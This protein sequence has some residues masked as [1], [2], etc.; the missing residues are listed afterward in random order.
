MQ[1]DLISP[2]EQDIQSLIKKLHDERDEEIKIRGQ[3][4]LNNGMYNSVLW[5]GRQINTNGNGSN[6]EDEYDRE[7][8]GAIEKEKDDVNVDGNV[9]EKASNGVEMGNEME[10][11]ISSLISKQRRFSSN[12]CFRIPPQV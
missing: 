3:R 11:P 12:Q 6:V 9:H 5:I 2:T 4:T 8:I 10:Q 7:K 1:T